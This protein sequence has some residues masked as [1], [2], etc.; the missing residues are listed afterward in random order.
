MKVEIL[1]S[2]E[3]LKAIGEWLKTA[4]RRFGVTGYAKGLDHAPSVDS[5]AE[6]IDGPA[7]LFSG[8]IK[9]KAPGLIVVEHSPW[10]EGVIKKPFARVQF[11]GADSY[12]GALALLRAATKRFNAEGVVLARASAGTAPGHIQAAY[13]AAGF[14]LASQLMTLAADIDHLWKKLERVPEGRAKFRIAT[15]D[16]ADAVARVAEGAF[17]E[18]R[19]VSDPNF[20]KKWGNKLYVNWARVMVQSDEH[21]LLIMEQDGTVVGCANLQRDTTKVPRVPGLFVVNKEAQG[22]GLGAVL[23]RR[24]IQEYR[25]AGKQYPLIATEKGNTAVNTLF[26]RLGYWIEDVNVIYHW[27]PRTSR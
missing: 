6:K 24:V 4:V 11:F 13:G 3:R 5:I 27:T 10:E 19:F 15:R 26:F 25:S 7:A 17:G 2:S 21:E 1:E 20:P 22:S 8:M 23:L 14:Y 9:G 18:G 16:D 12:E